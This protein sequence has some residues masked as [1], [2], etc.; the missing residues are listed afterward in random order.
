MVWIVV[1]IA[2]VVGVCSG[3]LLFAYLEKRAM[4][5]VIV[6]KVEDLIS[7]F[8]PHPTLSKGEGKKKR[9]GKQCRQ[10]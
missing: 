3:L 10:S 4:D 2:Y 7:H 1:F 5:K 6:V 9:K 8:N